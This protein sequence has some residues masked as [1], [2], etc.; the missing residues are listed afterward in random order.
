MKKS[1]AMSVSFLVMLGLFLCGTIASAS[2]ADKPVKLIAS[3]A[4]PNTHPYGMALGWM[5]DYLR[6]NLK[7]T[8]SLDVQL[9]V[10]GGER[11]I[12]EQ[13]VMGNIDLAAVS[14]M[15]TSATVMPKA[16]FANFP[17]LYKD[18]DEVR[19]LYW[20]GWIG[21]EVK[22]IGRD[23][24]IE[25]LSFFENC[26]RWI[27][28]SKRPIKTVADL[29]GLTMRVAEVPFMIDLFKALGTV[30]VPITFPE[31]ATAL[32][33]GIVDG[34]DNGIYSTYTLSFYEFNKY[35][36]YTKHNYSACF[37]YM[38]KEKFD[39]LSNKQQEDIR[40][41]AHY[42]QEKQIAYTLEIADTYIK[43]MVKAGVQ[44]TEPDPSMM[45]RFIEIG[46]E[47]LTR[48][49]YKKLFGPDLIRKMYQ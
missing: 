35:I 5:R 40:K 12:A 2:A 21:E 14:D 10:L 3:S 41:A 28:N 29:K 11:E 27:T 34:Q 30:T 46:K 39:S 13:T 24:G 49:S 31:L 8:V 6:D 47:L 20:E 36:T 43:E 16:S 25:I 45:V 7:S 9:L 17:G 22:K 42:V 44:M 32:Q 26:F 1:A 18:Y 38:N 33:Q 4:V 23:S 48:D 15:V 19:K 37:L